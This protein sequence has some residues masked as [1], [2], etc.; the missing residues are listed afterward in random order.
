MDYR[1]ITIQTAIALIA[2]SMFAGCSLLPDRSAQQTELQAQ[3]ANAAADRAEKSAQ[4]A[5]KAARDAMAAADHAEKTVHEDSKAIDADIARIN[6]LIAMHDRE[7]RRRRK[8]KK[9]HHVKHIAQGA[10]SATKPVAKTPLP[11]PVEEE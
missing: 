7:L 10:A 5:E 6:Y 11:A 9:H 1:A 3:R 8:T 2:L 4:A